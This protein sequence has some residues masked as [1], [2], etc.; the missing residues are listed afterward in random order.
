MKH[1]V[2]VLIN[3][4]IVVWGFQCG[5]YMAQTYIHRESMPEDFG[6]FLKHEL[7]KYRD[8]EKLRHGFDRIIL[9][10]PFHDK[11]E[12]NDLEYL[13]SNNLV[14]LSKMNTMAKKYN[15]PVS[16]NLKRSWYALLDQWVERGLEPYVKYDR[17]YMIDYD[18][19][20]D[21]TDPVLFDYIIDLDTEDLIVSGLG[22]TVIALDEIY[23]MTDDEFVKAIYDGDADIG[24]LLGNTEDEEDFAII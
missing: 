5:D 14:D 11:V 17:P 18:S 16:D 20:Q 15:I 19:V 9:I 2:K 13:L 4:P 24:D 3:A 23:N 21:I 12:D 8:I 1:G 7:C 6:I 10:D 22:E